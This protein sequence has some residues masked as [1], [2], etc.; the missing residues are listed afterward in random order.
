MNAAACQ[1]ADDD[2]ERYA[3]GKLSDPESAPLEEHLLL[4]PKCQKR[5]EDL[6][7]FIQVAKAALEVLSPTPPASRMYRFPLQIVGAACRSRCS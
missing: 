5:L 4:C 7:A 2:L 1:T 3:M 6:D